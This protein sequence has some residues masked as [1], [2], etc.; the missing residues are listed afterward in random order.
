MQFPL[1]VT[2]EAGS[3][4]VLDL[5]FSALEEVLIPCLILG[6]A[7]VSGRKVCT[8]PS[9]GEYFINQV[10]AVLLTGLFFPH[11]S[12]THHF[13]SWKMLPA[14]LHGTTASHRPQQWQRV[15][16]SAC[17]FEEGSSS[18]QHAARI[19]Y[20]RR[21]SLSFDNL[22][23]P[24]GFNS[25]WQ[26]ISAGQSPC[27]CCKLWHDLRLGC[28]L[29]QSHNYP[30]LSSIFCVKAALSSCQAQ[31]NIRS[32]YPQ[33]GVSH[34]QNGGIP[35]FY[36]EAKQ[37]SRVQWHPWYFASF[38]WLP[39]HM[40]LMIL[41]NC[42]NWIQLCPVQAQHVQRW[43]RLFLPTSIMVSYTDAQIYLFTQISEIL[44][45]FPAIRMAFDCPED[46]RSSPSLQLCCEQR[47]SWRDAQLGIRGVQPSLASCPPVLAPKN[48]KADFIPQLLF[49]IKSWH[50]RLLKVSERRKYL[51]IC[52]FSWNL[53]GT[54][55]LPGQCWR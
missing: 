4:C 48:L 40:E 7:R 30:F 28:P 39:L 45:R 32:P 42:Q 19:S 23:P 50:H 9:T 38:F 46:L 22:L 33:P 5:Y 3:V 8:D 17:T 6:I 47:Q 24:C 15:W 14:I 51:C 13:F 37:L 44:R 18:S 1:A 54:A 29:S 41:E 31:L 34:P 11:D 55:H 2:S 21:N 10:L 53:G 52:L 49:F 12:Q 20:R 43:P 26:P 35:R 36:M 27:E 25:R 16:S